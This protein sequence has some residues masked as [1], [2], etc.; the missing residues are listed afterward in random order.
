MADRTD[1]F[2]RLEEITHERNR[3]PVRAQLI[4][5]EDA[6]GQYD[7][8]VILRAHVVER[9]IDAH[10]AAF[11][12]VLQT[13]DLARFRRDHLDVAPAFSSA[14]FGASSSDCSKPSVARMAT[15]F[16]LSG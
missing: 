13:L 9:V 2:L 7:R 4:R 14:A 16:P 10:L 12:H 8:V 6:A 1:R 3:L 5:I 11:L 15:V